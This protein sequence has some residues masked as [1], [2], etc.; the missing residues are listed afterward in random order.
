MKRESST[1][2]V[3]VTAVTKQL[4]MTREQVIRRVQTG[5]LAGRRDERRGWLVDRTSAAALANARADD[6][7]PTAA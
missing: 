4:K 5:E 7:A 6:H 3:P 1:Q 2:L